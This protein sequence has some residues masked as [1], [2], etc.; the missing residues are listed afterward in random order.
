MTG[1][2]DSASAWLRILLV[3]VA[4]LVA[5][6]PDSAAGQ[7]RPSLT[8]RPA[9][10]LQAAGGEQC[11]QAIHRVQGDVL[12]NHCNECRNAQIQHQR[13]GVGFPVTRDFRVP[14]KGKVELSFKGSGK[15]RVVSDT[16]C[17]VDTQAETADVKDCAKLATR[18][19][20]EP[21]LMNACPICRGVVI[22]RVAS[23]GRSERQTFTLS[24]RTLLPLQ[25]RGAANIRIVKELPCKK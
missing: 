18:K 9:Y 2:L 16:P 22:E 7:T 13:R 15:T 12:V 10:R 3:F 20:G 1:Y 5:G 25:L 17:D 23:N 6:W 4:A 14:E 8:S 11:V 21:A 24:P 19:D